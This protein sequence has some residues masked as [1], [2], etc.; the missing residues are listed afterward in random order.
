[1]V[2]TNQSSHQNQSLSEELTLKRLTISL[3]RGRPHFLSSYDMTLVSTRTIQTKRLSLSS[4]ISLAPIM[5]ISTPLLLSPTSKWYQAPPTNMVIVSVDWISIWLVNTHVL[6][7]WNI[8]NIALTVFKFSYSTILQLHRT[9][10]LTTLVSPSHWPPFPSFLYSISLYLMILHL[11]KM[12]Q[13]TLT[14]S[15][16]YLFT[17]PVRVCKML[18][19]P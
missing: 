6:Q 10:L 15:I 8:F 14:T 19:S 9:N 4:Q 7:L 12:L 16:W 13:K 1:M 11:S 3:E 18:P 17:G 5:F 2:I